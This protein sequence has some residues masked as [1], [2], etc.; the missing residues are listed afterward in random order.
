MFRDDFDRTAFCERL[1]SVIP[2][3]GWTCVAFI[4]MPTHFHLVLAVD[5]D[6]LQPGM[7]ALFGPYAQAFN[8][9]WGRKGHLKAGPF[10]M[11]HVADDADL[12]GLVRYVARN[13]VRARI[14]EHPADWFWGSFCGSAGYAKPF[15]FVDDELVLS[16]LDDD[17]TE[18]QR[19]LRE[20]VEKP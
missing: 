15:A 6:R 18:A 7:Q 4:L 14:C 16:A 13:P 12:V 9:R 17:R 19:L 8:R 10:R 20:R 3:F 1:A 2:K 5:D 11:R